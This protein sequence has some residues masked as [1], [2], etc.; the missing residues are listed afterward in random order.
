[1]LKVSDRFYISVKI[2]GKEVPLEKLGFGSFQAHSN[3][4]F[5]VPIANLYLIDNSKYFDTNPVADGVLFEIYTG[6]TKDKGKATIYKFRHFKTDRVPIGGNLHSYNFRLVYNAPRYLNENMVSSLRGTS[7]S[8]MKA[9]GIQ[10]TSATVVT[11]TASDA[12]SWL[13]FGMKRCEF[14]R[15]VCNYAYAG[16]S[17]CYMLGLRLD[18]ALHFRNISTIDPSKT[19]NL[20]VKGT[21]KLNGS[22][23][24]IGDKEVASSGLANNVTGYKMETVEQGTGEDKSYTKVSVPTTSGTSMVSQHISKNISGSKMVNSPVASSNTHPNYQI[25]QHQNKRIRNTYMLST[26]VATDEMTNLDLF[27]T[28]KYILMEQTGGKPQ[29]NRKMSGTYIIVAK[30]IYVTKSGMYY[31]KFQMQRQGYNA[32]TVGAAIIKNLEAQ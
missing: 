13:P 18:G 31:E 21:S 8:V 17:S 25:A 16:S 1:M 7:S 2:A 9:L 4:N 24:I 15:H 10:I 12:M 29:L 32:D 27:D 11:D 6:T 5:Y 14:A 22:I 20:M 30:T 23:K 3:V 26:Y 28:A 19:T